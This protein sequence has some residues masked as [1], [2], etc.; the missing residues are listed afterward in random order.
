LRL[1]V[2]AGEE[3]ATAL[4]TALLMLA[5]A[6]PE[7]NVLVWFILTASIKYVV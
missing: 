5:V 4:D 2:V 1:V 3:P 7:N 6:G